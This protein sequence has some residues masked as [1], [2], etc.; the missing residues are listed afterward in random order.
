MNSIGMRE[1]ASLLKDAKD[2][3][4]M[5]TFHSIGDT[6]S[7]AAAVI[8][9]GML[10]NSQISTPDTITHNASNTLKKLGRSGSFPNSFIGDAELVVLVDVNNFEGCGPFEERLKGFRRDMLVI[11]H[12]AKNEIQGT[13]VYAFDDE[14][15]NSTSSMVY[16]LVK[17]LGED[18]SSTNAK[19]LALGILSDSAGFKNASYQTFYQL[20]ELFQQAG[21]SYIELQEEFYKEPL[22]ERRLEVLSDMCH[23]ESNVHS[24]MLFICG[25]AHG[26]AGDVADAAIDIGA[27]VSIFYSE[28]ENEVAFSARLRPTFDE[29]YSLHLGVIMKKA[30]NIIG[31]SGGGH[32]CAGG[33]YG[34]K[35]DKA[36]EFLQELITQISKRIAESHAGAM[37]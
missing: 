16:E 6:D 32:P 1:A 21:T 23:S 33:A 19:L 22:P 30:A 14:S 9:S 31:G 11:D 27:D 25:A 2:K 34:P 15:Y 10:K 17:E 28:N 24:G 5:I 20:A 12:H 36:D 26:H 37:K 7:V 13:S 3:K 8:L 35:K 4:V 29:K 18:I